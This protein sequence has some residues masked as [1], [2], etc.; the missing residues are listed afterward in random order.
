MKL[1]K[2]SSDI[3]IIY[4]HTHKIDKMCTGSVNLQK[5]NRTFCGAFR[6]SSNLIN[7]LIH[8]EEFNQM[9]FNSIDFELDSG[10]IA[11]LIR[12]ATATATKQIVGGNCSSINIRVSFIHNK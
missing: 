4:T 2:K 5:K 11:F 8:F 3:L 10:L 9:E 7:V 1:T 12:A 6:F